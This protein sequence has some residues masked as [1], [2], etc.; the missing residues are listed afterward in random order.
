MEESTSREKVLK[1]IRN[2][3]LE[4]TDNPFSR[5]VFDSPILPPMEEGLEVAFAERLMQTGG[6]FV[7][8]E[9]ADEVVANLK[10]LASAIDTDTLLCLEGELQGLLNRA[11]LKSSADLDA[12]REQ[13]AGFTSCE[14]LVARSGSIIVSSRLTGGRKLNAFPDIHIVLGRTSQLVPEIAD[15]LDALRTRYG[16]RIPSVIS[17]VT[18][19]SRTADIEKTLVMGAHGPRELYLLLLE[20][21]F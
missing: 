19:P 18:G 1:R 5:S 4:K 2:A 9:N 20:D 7:Y 21:A 8:C 17:M 10:A 3:L 14:A 15:A 13:G 11:G 6:K 12:F 16:V